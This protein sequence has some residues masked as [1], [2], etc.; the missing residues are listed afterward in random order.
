MIAVSTFRHLPDI[1]HAFL[2]K[3]IAKV[4]MGA[5]EKSTFV[6]RHRPSA[7]VLTSQIS[8]AVVHGVVK[9]LETGKQTVDPFQILLVRMLITGIGC[10]AWLYCKRLPEFPLGPHDTRQMLVLRAVGGVLGAGGMYCKSIHT[11]NTTCN[12]RE[13]LTNGADSIMYLTL[14]QATALNFLAPMGAMILSKH[15]DGGN[16]TLIDRA[17]AAVALAGV[18]MVVQPDEIFHSGD[19][20][21]LGSRPKT[22][23][24]AKLKGISCGLVGVLG[25]IV[26]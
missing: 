26:R 21:P 19:T 24:F 22:E 8:A 4:M 11:R 15:M 1:P 2:L 9:S 17:G 10:S 13:V 23:A 3:M 18:I 14:S 16:F 25:T 20:L 12:A 7:V 5:R 6:A